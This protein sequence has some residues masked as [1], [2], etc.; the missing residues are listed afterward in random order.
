MLGQLRLLHLLM[1]FCPTGPTCKALRLRLVD[2]GA[3]GEVI[4][5]LRLQEIC[6]AHIE[7]GLWASRAR[8]P[9]ETARTAL[10]ARVVRLLREHLQEAGRQGA[11]TFCVEGHHRRLDEAMNVSQNN[12]ASER[13]LLVKNPDSG[14]WL[15]DSQL[16]RTLG[17]PGGAE[18]WLAGLL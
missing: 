8:T 7:G 3:V 16:W 18:E 5:T 13:A 9:A 12:W 15:I 2:F 10:V 1:E 11:P 17:L 6:A 14:V 4:D